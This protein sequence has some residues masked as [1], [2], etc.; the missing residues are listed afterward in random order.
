MAAPA[1]DGVGRE[2]INSNEHQQQQQPAERSE[3][4]QEASSSGLALLSLDLSG[5][6]R[7]SLKSSSESGRNEARF[8][9]QFIYEPRVIR[10]S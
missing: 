1:E 9:G 2:I 10:H 3:E 8:W 7:N 4:A 6:R 5:L